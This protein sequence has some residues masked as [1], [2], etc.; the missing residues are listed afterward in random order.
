MLVLD[1]LRFATGA[2]ATLAMMIAIS[3]HDLAKSYS[4]YRAGTFRTALRRPHIIHRNRWSAICII[5]ASAFLFL[6]AVTH[7]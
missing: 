6:M 5:N 4:K 7:V 1:V 3:H 2:I